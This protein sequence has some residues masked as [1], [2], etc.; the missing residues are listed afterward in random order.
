MSYS[1]YCC[2]ASNASFKSAPSV[3]PPRLRV[4]RLLFLP[5]AMDLRIN[6]NLPLVGLKPSANR[7]LIDLRPSACFL[8]DTMRP[9]FVLTK[10]ARFTCPAVQN[11]T[12]WNTSALLP[13]RFWNS[14]MF[15][16]RA[17]EKNVIAK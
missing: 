6:E 14:G 17:F 1:I 4:L 10:P 16:T 8:R 7:R 12:P 2:M 11:A 5:L 9:A 3:A 13:T 15:S